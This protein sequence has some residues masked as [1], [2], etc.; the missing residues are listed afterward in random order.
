MG[1]IKDYIKWRGDLEFSQDGFNEIDNLV[2]SCVSYVKMDDILTSVLTELSIRDIGDAYFGKNKD[3]RNHREELHHNSFVIDPGDRS[4]EA[5]VRSHRDRSVLTD[6]PVI[7]KAIA[8]TNRYKNIRVRNYLTMNDT[9]RTLQFAAMEFLLPDGTS[10]VAYRG[11]DDTVV[12]WKEDFMLAL[13]ET[14]AEK[15]AVAYINKIARFTGRPLRIGG[16][17]K[18]GH[19]AVFAAAKCD[20][21]IKDRIIN[22]YSNDGPGFMENMASSRE[23]K[24]ILPK[25]ISIIPEESI[26]GLLMVPVGTPAIVKSTARSVR[27]HNL[28]TWQLHGKTLDTVSDVSKGAKLTD[29][30][31]KE[32]IGRMSPEELN[33]FIDNLFSVFD[34]A[35]ASTFKEFKKGG[36][37][38]LQAV[39]QKVKEDYKSRQA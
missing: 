38:S 6:A 14:E 35:G 26:V 5:S 22:V 37:K 27:Q 24:E 2:L 30:F 9:E 7:L 3:N 25:L 32:N 23:I 13:K 18:G 17:S 20:G 34:A 12:G 4:D 33:E 19:L 16:H 31:I 1:T 39:I 29:R 21:M 11:T 10:Y 15:E 28:A 36:L 8:E